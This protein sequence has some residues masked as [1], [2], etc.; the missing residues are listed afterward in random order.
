MSR[1]AARAALALAVVCAPSSATPQ[2]APAQAPKTTFRSAVDVVSVA[3]VVRDKRGRFAPNLKKE[4]FVVEEAGTRRDI[5]QFHADTNAPVRVALLFDVSGSMRLADRI[6]EARQAARHVLGALRLGGAADEAAVFSFDMNLQSLQPFTVDAGA[7]ETALA[8]VA[9]YGQTSLYDAIAQTARRVADTRPGDPHRR[10]VVVFTDGVDTS[11]LLTPEQV[12][13]IASEI[14]VPVYV[15][16]VVS[17]S[18]YED[19]GARHAVPDSVLRTLAQWTGGDLFVT[20]AP[21][22][23]SVAARQIV[24]ELRHQYLIAFAASPASGWHALD[25]KTRDRDLTVRARR[26]Y[27]AG[28][29]PGSD[30]PTASQAGQWTP[31]EP[32]A[33]GIRQ[34][35]NEAG[36][37]GPRPSRMPMAFEQ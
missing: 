26:G 25:V 12:S 20:S 13:A 4:D 3:A 33:H 34:L 1:T 8:R 15:M 10:A 36:R 32:N 9:P 6:D 17:P 18:D 28:K 19:H 35:K 37:P 31:A 16:T 29:R 22:H 30:S 27:S 24:D 21:A 14:D 7:I 5:V 2:D 23:E 11:S